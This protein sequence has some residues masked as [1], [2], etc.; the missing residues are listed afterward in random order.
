MRLFLDV[1]TNLLY[2][3][4]TIGISTKVLCWSDRQDP[5]K[6]SFDTLRGTIAPLLVL[7]MTSWVQA[8]LEQVWSLQPPGEQFDASVEG[9]S[10]GVLEARWHDSGFAEGDDNY[11][12]VTA[13]GDGK[14]FS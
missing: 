6:G 13:A 5:F 4:A 7:L 9:P 14:I 3:H 1:A 12:A 8:A 10:T 11:N 2:C